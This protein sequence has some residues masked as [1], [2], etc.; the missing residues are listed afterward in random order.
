MSRL[1]GC[2]LLSLFLCWTQAFADESDQRTAPPP[3]GI[4]L[5]LQ[6]AI[7]LA[8]S[9][10]PEVSIADVQVTRAGDF[11]RETRA[12]NRPQ[13]IAGTG[14]AYNNGY[15]LSIEGAAP[16][17]FQIGLTQPVFNRRNKNLILEAEEGIKAT[18]IGSESVRNEVAAQTALA[19]YDLHQARSMEALWLARRDAAATEQQATETL[20]QAGKV[21]PLDLSV[22]RTAAAEAEQQLLIAREG[23]RLADAVLRRLTG[24]TG[25]GPILTSEPQL[26]QE[27][28]G[29]SADALLQKVL[30]TNP[31]IRQAESDLRAR[32]F[33][34]EAEKSGKY[35]R[36]EFVTEYALFTRYNN[37][38]DFFS[39]FTRNNFLAGLSIQVP[40]FDGS[41]TSARVAQS[42]QQVL[43]ARIRLERT[44]S[45]LQMSLERGVSVLRIARGATELARRELETAEEVVRVNRSLMEGGRITPKDLL[46]SENQARDK[47]IGLL[48][49]QKSLFQR[50]VELLRLT[51]SLE[52]YY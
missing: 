38:Q 11:L 15:P 21:R 31:V 42:R 7:K 23:A 18:R 28:L 50:Q 52:T 12:S 48:D 35:P 45:D 16:S 19:Y 39:T 22:A 37:Y 44:K 10:A 43:E 32:E 9:R 29:M 20:L 46:V 1:P 25:P 6:E 4:A 33:R 26:D 17:A 30:Q 47:E 3:G 36:L 8:V 34:V 49:A 13:V 5:T 41:L 24:Q 40:L 51:G 27:V 14:L 2:F